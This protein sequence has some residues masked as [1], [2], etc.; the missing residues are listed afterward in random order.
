[1]AKR[2][3]LAVLTTQHGLFIG[4]R[5]PSSSNLLVPSTDNYAQP[6]RIVP[7]QARSPN[8]LRSSR[9]A[10]TQLQIPLTGIQPVYSVRQ[11]DG[12]DASHQLAAA[13]ARLAQTL[14]LVIY[15]V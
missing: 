14:Q 1:M 8:L 10:A 13:T 12:P 5:P 2:L 4:H 7:W 3:V 15:M 9:I 6:E 11:P